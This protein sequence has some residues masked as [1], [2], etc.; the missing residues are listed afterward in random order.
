MVYKEERNLWAYEGT[1]SFIGIA[2]PI[3]SF[4]SFFFF[5]LSF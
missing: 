3:L 2:L 1:L 4:P 5:P